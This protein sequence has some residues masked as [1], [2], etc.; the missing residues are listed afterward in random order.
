LLTLKQKEYMLY[1]IG[2][3]HGELEQL[4][5]KLAIKNIRNSQLVQVGDFGFGFFG[6]KDKEDLS[7]KN[8]NKTLKAGNN[9]LY[10]IRGNHD[11]PSYFEKWQKI[12]NIRLV[13]DYS[14][15]ELA[16][17][18]VLLVGGAISID[19]TSRVS[20]KT[21]W[22][23]EEFVFNQDKLD[24]VLRDVKKIDIVVTHSAPSE[25][26]P[27]DFDLNVHSYMARDKQLKADLDIDRANHSRL[28]KF[29]TM[30]FSTTRWYYGHFHA[31]K[32]GEYNDIKYHL[33]GELEIRE[34]VSL[35]IKA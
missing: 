2:D 33:L 7:I 1:F 25:F 17:N 5:D 26:W 8:L 24:A 14:V 35:M 6:S 4:A 23:E 3:V 21:Y 11:D 16:G 28:L 10:V 12:G 27:Y 30:R 19:R 20:G 22:R 15:L 34:Y 13:P 9:L 32:G 29:I 18:S 31:S